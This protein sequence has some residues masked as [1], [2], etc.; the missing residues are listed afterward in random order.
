MQFYR[1][2]QNQ[3]IYWDLF[4]LASRLQVASSDEKVELRQLNLPPA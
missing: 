4:N 1:E 3:H 2:I